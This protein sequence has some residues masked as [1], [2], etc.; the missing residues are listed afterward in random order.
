MIAAFAIAALIAG[1]REDA[2][3]ARERWRSCVINRAT[4]YAT[5]SEPAETLARAALG[6]CIQ[7]R[8]AFRDA[9]RSAERGPLGLG[10]PPRGEDIDRVVGDVAADIS[11][12]AIAA[13]I[14]RRAAGP[15]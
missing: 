11:Q 6:R 4:I 3:A 14:D 1:S 5:Q 7:E 8:G 10:L 15:Q 13:I 12:M 9:I 2:L